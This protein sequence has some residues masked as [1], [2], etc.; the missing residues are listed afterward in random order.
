[1]RAASTWNGAVNS[2]DLVR[3]RRQ[4]QSLPRRANVPVIVL[5]V[6]KGHTKDFLRELGS[7]SYQTE[8]KPWSS[9]QHL[10]VVPARPSRAQKAWRPP[11]ACSI[12]PAEL[13][14]TR[15]RPSR[16]LAVA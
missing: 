1:M 16:K 13:P 4:V 5:S 3:L 7:S 15:L 14:P 10:G 6:S 12:N 9:V 2:A 8:C 11:I